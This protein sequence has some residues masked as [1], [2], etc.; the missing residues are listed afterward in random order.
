MIILTSRSLLRRLMKMG[1]FMKMHA[2]LAFEIQILL[3]IGKLYVKDKLHISIMGTTFVIEL[4]QFSISWNDKINSSL[5]VFL[6]FEY[7]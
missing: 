6:Y 4:W 3:Q 5:V 1:Y 7:I 2:T